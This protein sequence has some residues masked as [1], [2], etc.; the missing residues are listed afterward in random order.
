MEIIKLNCPECGSPFEYS[1]DT[2]EGT[3]LV[4]GYTP[5]KRDI[6]SY[7]KLKEEKENELKEEKRKQD[8][9]QHRI[10]EE[11]RR[12][13][14]QILIKKIEEENKKRRAEEELLRKKKAEEEK[15]RKETEERKKEL[16]RK[17][18]LERKKKIKKLKR[19]FSSVGKPI[20]IGALII[21]LL[22]S[23]FYYFKVARP[24]NKY[25]KALAYVEMEDYSKAIKIF[26][27]LDDY[28]D[29]ESLYKKCRIMAGWDVSFGTYS[30]LFKGKGGRVIYWKVKMHKGTKYLLVADET[31]YSLEFG[32]TSNNTWKNSKVRR[33]LKE[34]FDNCFTDEEKNAILTTNVI[35]KG[36]GTTEDKLFILSPAE[37][38]GPAKVY[39]HYGWLRPE[40]GNLYY[41]YDGRSYEAR[42]GIEDNEDVRPAMWI[43]IEL[44]GANSNS[45]SSEFKISTDDIIS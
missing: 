41:G 35:T 23:P 34:D 42:Q 12:I 19:S 33:F 40:N 1:I 9:E 5:S 28:R 18:K 13:E 39:E 31:W 8:E 10:E 2:N 22:C 7:F 26:G 36:E 14:K 27:K 44:L 3:C 32:E 20:I 29:S 4:C 38:E 43:D 15:K 6:D 37:Y 30:D 17:Q 11:K 25:E 16:A 24:R 45:A 21:S